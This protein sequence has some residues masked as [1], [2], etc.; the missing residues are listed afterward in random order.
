MIIICEP[1]C[2][3]ISHEKVNSGFIYGLNK[4][5]SKDKTLF[6]ADKSH[7]RAIQSIFKT[8]GVNIKNINLFPIKFNSDASFSLGGVARYYLLLQ[9]VFDRLLTLGES[10]I[11][12]LSVNPVI[13]YTV[14][15]LKQKAKYKNINC[16]FVLHGELEDVANKKFKEPYSP[17]IKS[18]SDAA[19]LIKHPGILLLFLKNLISS[20]FLKLYSRYSLFFKERF[21]T[22]EM[23]MWQHSNQYKYISMSPHVTRNAGKYLDTNYLNFHTIIMPVIFEKPNLAPD[24]KNIKFAVFGYGDSAQMNR[25]LTLLSRK[26]ISKNYE[27]KIIGMDGRGTEEFFNVNHIGKGK[28]LSREEMENAAKDVD[29]FINLYEKNR[30]RFGCSLSIFESL[31]YVKPVL[32]LSNDGYNYFNKPEKPIG[33]RAENLDKFV[34]KMYDMIEHYPKY[35]KDLTAFRKNILD[36]RRQY[37]IENNLDKLKASF[38]FD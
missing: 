36:Y 5:Y 24:N 15:K 6:F 16:T 25:M 20:P 31:S 27:I 7:F 32:H 9:K 14:K 17:V 29:I 26:K 1:Q 8:N 28:V 37:A 4:A 19:R 23:M 10:K 12:F 34:E 35:K 13:L 22:K 2:K 18:R 21:R 3:G 11:F 30:H 33:Y 38:T